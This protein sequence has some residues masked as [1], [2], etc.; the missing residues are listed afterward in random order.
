[1]TPANLKAFHS[2]LYEM[3]G[4]RP[5]R[6][7]TLASLRLFPRQLEFG[8]HKDMVLDAKYVHIGLGV[9]HFTCSSI[10]FMRSGNMKNAG[11]IIM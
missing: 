8:N 2:E 7:V 10:K 4:I 3:M 1:M 9:F 11:F 6:L 5:T